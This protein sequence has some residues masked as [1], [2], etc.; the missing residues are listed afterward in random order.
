MEG[1]GVQ[2]THV[3]YDISGRVELNGGLR[4][5]LSSAMRS[6]VQYDSP[7]GISARVEVNGG[8]G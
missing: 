1:R 5:N 7:P 3:W 2:G 6:P 4:R 8:W